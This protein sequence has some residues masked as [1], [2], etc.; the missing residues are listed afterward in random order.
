MWYGGILQAE[1]MENLTGMRLE[2]YRIVFPRNSTAQVLPGL[3][4]TTVIRK[5]VPL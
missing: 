1:G 2:G 3:V 4:H 5:T